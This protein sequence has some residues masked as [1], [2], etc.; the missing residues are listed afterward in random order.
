VRRGSYEVRTDT[1]FLD[2]MRA[3]GE[4]PR[5]GQDGTWITEELI[6]GYGA[7]HA[8]GLAHSIE[9]WSN[10][11]LVGGLYGVSLGRVFFGESM[12]TRAPDASKVAFATLLGNLV[13]WDFALVDCQVYTDHLD[14]FG[15]VEWPRR[16]FLRALEAALEAS[17]R[18]GPWRFDLEPAQAIERLIAR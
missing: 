4:S 10:G 12:F 1:A 3:C 9:S 16:Q 5:P 6:A 15:A 13:A 18:V 7:L 8:A 14:R 2:V 17:T 11:E